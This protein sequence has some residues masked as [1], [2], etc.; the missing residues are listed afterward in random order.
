MPRHVYAL[1]RPSKDVIRTLAPFPGLPLFQI[2]QPRSHED[3]LFARRELLGARVVGLDTETKPVFVKGRAAAG[4]HVVQL[5]TLR[6][7]LVFSID[8]YGGRALITEVLEAEHIMKVGFGLE[9]DCESLRRKLGATVRPTMELSTVFHRLGYRARVGLQTAVA[10]VLGMY[11]EKPKNVVR[12]NWAMKWLTKRQLRY[13][14]NDAYASLC[15][16]QALGLEAPQ[17]RTGTRSARTT[18]KASSC[19]TSQTSFKAKPES[20][21]KR[22]S[23]SA[24][25]NTRSHGFAKPGLASKN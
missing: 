3:F 19:G 11:L 8:H 22:S 7:V 14:A 6:H 20:R 5:A 13:A 4:P 24:T 9:N 16:F 2:H 17:P 15:V 10:I 23:S 12:S 21:L 18:R 1:E 25:V